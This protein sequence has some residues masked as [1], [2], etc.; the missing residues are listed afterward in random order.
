MYGNDTVSFVVPIQGKEGKEFMI[1][2]SRDLCRLHWDQARQER[3][4]ED[5]AK[6]GHWVVVLAK[7]DRGQTY[8]RFNDG[9]VDPQ[10]RLWAGLCSTQRLKI[11]KKKS[12]FDFVA[13]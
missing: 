1:G 9:K 2:R 7:V 10:G 13:N 3:E 5:G 6:L 4:T 8:N 12:H 11:N